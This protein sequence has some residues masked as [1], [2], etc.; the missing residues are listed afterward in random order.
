MFEAT[1]D[2]QPV[3]A[4]GF[5]EWYGKMPSHLERR[6]SYNDVGIELKIPAAASSGRKSTLIT[7]TTDAS[8]ATFHWYIDAGT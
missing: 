5:T 2:G 4:A 7:L 3:Y 8:N 1:V 6:V